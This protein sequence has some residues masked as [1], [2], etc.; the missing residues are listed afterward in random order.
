MNV[1]R[2]VLIA[3]ILLLLLITLLHGGAPKASKE[4]ISILDAGAPQV[5]VIIKLKPLDANGKG[6]GRGQQ[7]AS[8]VR[9]KGRISRLN[10][11]SA[12]ITEEELAL[13]EKDPNVEAVYYNF[14]VYATL[15]QSVPLV[16]ADDVF[17]ITYNGTQ[18]NGSGYSICIID[19]GANYSHPAL[20]G[21]TEAQFL[22]GACPKVIGGYD[23][24]NDDPNPMDDHGHGTHVAGIIASTDPTY[25]GVAP[26]ASIVALKALN[27]SGSGTYYDILESIEW[28]ISNASTYNITAISMSLGTDTTFGTFCDG[29]DAPGSALVNDSVAAGI[30]VV[31]ATGNSYST[32]GISWP[33][34]LAQATR[35]SA[36][37]K[38]DAVA[39]FANRGANFSDIIMAPGVSIISASRLGGFVANSGTS[40]ATPHVSGAIALMRDYWEHVN[41]ATLTPAE[42][43]ERLNYTKVR[44]DD[45]GGSG[46]YYPRLDVLE[47][48]RPAPAFASPTPPNNGNTTQ[49]FI[50]NITSPTPL[51][52]AVLELTYP[53]STRI[54]FSMVQHS[55]YSFS[56]IAPTVEFGQYNFTAFTNDS[57]GTSSPPLYRSGVMV[58]AAISLD[59]PLNGQTQKTSAITLNCSFTTFERN[60]SN[61]TLYGNFTGEWA[62]NQTVAVSGNE[63]NASFTIDVV[64]GTYAWNCYGVDEHGV[65]FFAPQ[66]HTFTSDPLPP[67]VA[68]LSPL[69][70]EVLLRNSTLNISAL[71]SDI[72]GISGAYANLSLPNGTVLTFVLGNSGGSLYSNITEVP[73]IGCA[74]SIAFYAN[75]SLGDANSSEQVQYIAAPTHTLSATATALATN[76]TVPISFTANLTVPACWQADS[77]TIRASNSSLVSPAEQN[78]SDVAPGSE[79]E[80]NFTANYPRA[81]N[82][83]FTI[84][85]T[86]HSYPALWYSLTFTFNVG[87]YCGNG[88]CETG[89]TR[90][91]CPADCKSSGG[92]GGG[93]GGGSGGRGGGS[94][95]SGGGGG[96]GTA[97][98]PKD[99]R[100]RNV[101]APRLFTDE[102][103]HTFAVGGK[104]YALAQCDDGGCS[105]ADSAGNV[106]PPDK[107]AQEISAYLASTETPEQMRSRILTALAE[108]NRSRVEEM[109]CR[110]QF[111]HHISP[112]TNL[113]SCMFGCRS[114]PLCA[115][116]SYSEIVLNMS[117][118]LYSHS[119]SLSAL[120]S[121]CASRAVNAST[122]E[123]I[124]GLGQCLQAL[125]DESAAIASSPLF[126]TCPSCLSVCPETNYSYVSLGGAARVVEDANKVLRLRHALALLSAQASAAVPPQ[127]NATVEE[128]PAESESAVGARESTVEAAPPA[129]GEDL[130]LPIA[131]AVFSV[132][133]LALGYHYRKLFIP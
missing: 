97:I 43:K 96:G 108:F 25:K 94:G 63:T 110:A 65:G 84:S 15:H 130:S 45:T 71:I 106:L 117:H 4:V 76:A 16:N 127:A 93:G 50:V 73:D 79:T 112:C 83:T 17:S 77:Y 46:L 129:G 14:P 10:I 44:I 67:A 115:P 131:V 3:S 48:I 105:V 111:G 95:G 75:D 18:I 58:L 101:T 29:A 31:V 74:H 124:A 113:S 104:E 12:T 52:S 35:V 53:N 68:P 62:A 109:K 107:A 123:D 80:I 30:P 114:V 28:C 82:Y 13:L 49:H 122:Y 92:G 41:S 66:N 32:T 47:S 91:A 56:I 89:E 36:T 103:P 72:S 23:F 7:V 57:A 5:D 55:P 33:A 120:Y 9:E 2:A 102:V 54:N 133:L 87:P 128:A 38:S 121:E 118:Y 125:S 51:S 85:A 119:E 88:R 37:D 90:L 99:A 126:G 26:G 61:I 1:C 11:I 6:K 132:I 70:S 60:A 116:L 40:M 42:I 24:V 34:C 69:N 59:Y 78:I 100:Y 22:A 98:L 81:G 19:T 86:S 20:G 27:A 39:S 21:C 64:P 8:S